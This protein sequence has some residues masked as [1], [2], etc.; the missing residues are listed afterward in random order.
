MTVDR[1]ADACPDC[2]DSATQQSTCFFHSYFAGV[3]GDDKIKIIDT[4]GIKDITGAGTCDRINTI[5]A[6]DLLQG[7]EAVDLTL[8][9]TKIGREHNHDMLAQ[10]QESYGMIWNR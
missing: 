1:T 10:L 9:V 7:V 6:V 5:H 3:F 8:F 2:S 4:P